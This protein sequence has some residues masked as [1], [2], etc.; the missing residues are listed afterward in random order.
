VFTAVYYCPKLIKEGGNVVLQQLHD[1]A[2]V[3]PRI[4]NICG[5]I[6]DILAAERWK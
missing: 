1:N 3:N 6:L 5:T 2:E 4:R